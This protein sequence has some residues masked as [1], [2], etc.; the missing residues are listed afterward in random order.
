MKGGIPLQASKPV[1]RIQLTARLLMAIPLLLLFLYTVPFIGPAS[2]PAVVIIL[3][4]VPFISQALP[5]RRRAALYLGVE[6]IYALIILYLLFTI[7]SDSAAKAGQI[8]AAIIAGGFAVPFIFGVEILRSR[9]PTAALSSF[10]VGF[11]TVLTELATITYSQVNSLPVT[12]SYIDVWSLQMR[13]LISLLESGYQTGLPLQTLQIATP[14][15]M[16]LLLLPVVAG[17]MLFVST[18]SGALDS[19]R[20][21]QAVM[22][23]MTGAAVTVAVLAIVLLLEG[24]GLSITVIGL[25][26]LAV[27]ILVARIARST[28]RQ[29]QSS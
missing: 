13:G 22:Q 23:L 10:I 28:M 2:N 26:V 5:S 11:G 14:A 15:V 29:F 27:F 17:F 12:T 20:A 1:R 21:E 24:S 4:P 3:I 18:G 16:V 6:V 7:G 9:S 25:S 19:V 8:Y